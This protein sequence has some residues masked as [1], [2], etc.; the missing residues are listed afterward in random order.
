MLFLLQSFVAWIAAA[1]ALGL[2]C[3]LPAAWAGQGLR[4][5]ARGALLAVVYC[6]GVAAAA[7]QLA[8]GRAG[9]WLETGLLI[10]AP[11]RWA[12]FGAAC[13]PSSCRACSAVARAVRRRTGARRREIL[14][15]RLMLMPPLRAKA[16]PRSM[17]RPACSR[18]PRPPRRLSPRSR[19]PRRSTIWRWFMASIASMPRFCA[20]RALPTAPPLPA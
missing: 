2:V 6:S 13:A 10:S 9:F 19:R 17:R 12:C 4:W 11:T 3:G 7:L 1:L 20:V 5:S 18:R 15:A 8:P 14:P 16:H